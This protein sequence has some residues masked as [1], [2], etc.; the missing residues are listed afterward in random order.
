MNRI[1]AQDTIKSLKQMFRTWGPPRTLTLDN[2]KQFVSTEFKEFCSN[3]GIHLNHTTPYWPQ[4]NGEVERQNRSLLKRMKIAHALHDNWKAELEHYLNLYNNTPHTITGKAPSELL[5]GRKL[6][7]K[8][9]QVDDLE[10]VPPSTDF[11]DQD[12]AKKIQQKEREDTRRRAKPN[13]IS[14]GD[15]VLMKNLLPSNKLA[16]PFLNEKFTVLGR[17]GSNVTVQSNSSGKQFD[18]NISH[19]KKWNGSS[20]ADIGGPVESGESFAYQAAIRS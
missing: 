5:Q 9:P 12:M 2:A 16:T 4:A 15:T 18:R 8:L 3:N 11:R 20:D 1:T 19:L 13:D 17:N 7:S 6:R 14:T 10:T